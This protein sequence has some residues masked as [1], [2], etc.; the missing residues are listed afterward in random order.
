MALT[1]ERV[2]TPEREERSAPELDPSLLH[3][4]QTRAGS[5][6][7]LLGAWVVAVFSMLLFEPAPSAPVEPSLF[8]DAIFIAF[9]LAF[10]ATVFGLSAGRDWALKA[11]GAAAGIGVVIAVACAVTDHHMGWWWASELAAFTFL[12]GMTLHSAARSR[13]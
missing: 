5:R 12:G 9:T 7:W 13:S 10:T 6:R 8:A 11:S 3:R 1:E 2:R 4:D